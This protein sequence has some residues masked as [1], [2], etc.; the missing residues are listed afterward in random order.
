MPPSCQ[1]F[2][3][4]ALASAAAKKKTS[5]PPPSQS[6]RDPGTPEPAHEDPPIPTSP[7]NRN[8]NTKKRKIP[9]AKDYEQA[10]SVSEDVRVVPPHKNKSKTRARDT[11]PENQSPP[12]SE[13]PKTTPASPPFKM[14][15]D[16]LLKHPSIIE[17]P[18]DSHS[19]PNLFNQP[20]LP[21]Y[22]STDMVKYPLTASELE[23]FMTGQP[24]TQ[25]N[26]SYDATAVENAIGYMFHVVTDFFAHRPHVLPSEKED[27]AN[28]F[29]KLNIVSRALLHTKQHPD[30][31]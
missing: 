4:A 20:N 5:Q 19:L 2:K 28:L 11:E 24:A 26:P 3:D 1:S 14:F 22:Y 18:I 17:R 6:R 12:P 13:Y 21:A 27:R 16:F 8:N 7:N 15:R 31:Q 10:F 29:T 9:P 30:S 23:I 25:S